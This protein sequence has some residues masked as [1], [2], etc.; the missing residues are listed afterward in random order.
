MSSP[1]KIRSALA[2]FIFASG[3]IASAQAE[4]AS[5]SL[6][7][8]LALSLEDLLSTEISL[9]SRKLQKIRESAAAVHIVTA[10]EIRRMG[11]SSIPDALR[12]VPG[13][14]VGRINAAQ[15]SVAI[16]GFSGRHSDK[17][18]VLIDG[19]TI[20]LP[21]FSGVYWEEHDL[22]LENIERIEVIRGP[23]AT[24]WGANAV[25][26]IINIITKSADENLKNTLTAATG[27][28]E[29]KHMAARKQFSLGEH[30]QGY[31]H[32]KHTSRDSLSL[33]SGANANDAWN[34]QRAGFRL[35]GVNANDDNWTLTA[36]VFDNQSESA[37]CYYILILT[38]R[39][40]SRLASPWSHAARFRRE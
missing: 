23:G 34:T 10:D 6:D 36:D 28:F 13:V 33:L 27:S 1:V 4:V 12:L 20:Y 2:A 25:N 30:V 3:L 16:R 26:G 14:Q 17:L 32:V 39:K 7:N 31:A 11:A 40:N 37:G 29:R 8:Y 9:V 15:E 35:D 21:S 19:R 5:K 38:R 22:M 24:L 18:L